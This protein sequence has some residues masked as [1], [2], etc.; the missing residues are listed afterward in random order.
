MTAVA[1]KAAA[2]AP[3]GGGHRWHHPHV[4][5]GHPLW[6]P[7]MG[8]RVARSPR[9]KTG[10]APPDVPAKTQKSPP[11]PQPRPPHRTRRGG[12]GGPARPK[13]RKSHEWEPAC[14][15]RQREE[16]FHGTRGRVPSA[17]GRES[18]RAGGGGGRA[19]RHGWEDVGGRARHVAPGCR[20]CKGGGGGRHGF[21]HH[22]PGARDGFDVVSPAAASCLEPDA[23]NNFQS[24]WLGDEKRSCSSHM[25]C[26]LSLG[27][28]NSVT[29]QPR[30]VDPRLK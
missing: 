11:P 4:A 28:N 27:E 26:R 1:A 23:A 7:P 15:H 22:P 16:G 14:A 30:S 17:G 20:Q 24:V 8:H 6:Q 19:P 12:G 9:L 29:L 10:C 21:P 3:W 18:P 2:A 5:A 13:R 25:P